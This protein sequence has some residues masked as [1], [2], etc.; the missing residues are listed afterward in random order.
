MM[1]GFMESF[2]S[3]ALVFYACTY[4]VNYTWTDDGYTTDL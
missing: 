3:A 2:L 1:E 4:M